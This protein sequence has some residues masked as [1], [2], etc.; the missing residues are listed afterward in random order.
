MTWGGRGVGCRMILSADKA[1]LF[2]P[3]S[4]SCRKWQDLVLPRLATSDSER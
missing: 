4:S 1:L 3:N 2:E